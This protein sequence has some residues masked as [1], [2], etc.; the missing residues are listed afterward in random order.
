MQLLLR[1]IINYITSLPTNVDRPR[2]DAREIKS[3][4][5]TKAIKEMIL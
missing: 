3:R 5:E 4:K 1:C 2:Q